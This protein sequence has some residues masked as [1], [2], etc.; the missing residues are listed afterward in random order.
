MT[1]GRFA[2]LRTASAVDRAL[3]RVS[4][5]GP[6]LDEPVPPQEDATHRGRTCIALPSRIPG[7]FSH[8]KRELAILLRSLGPSPGWFSPMHL[9]HGPDK[10]D[11]GLSRSESIDPSH[12]ARVGYFLGEVPG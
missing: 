4:S 7:A 8:S 5:A 6:D 1:S 9:R 11:R 3:R 2:A 10:E 12:I